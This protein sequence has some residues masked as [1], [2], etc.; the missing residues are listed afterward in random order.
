[1]SSPEKD[2]RVNSQFVYSLILVFLIP[3]VL[4]GN[5]F[6]G[7]KN[8]QK[9]Q[10]IEIEKRG[11]MAGEIFAGTTTDF[12][13]DKNALQTSLD[14]LKESQSEIWEISLLEPLDDG[15]HTLA[16][17]KPENLDL[18]YQSLRFSTAWVEEK[19]LTLKQADDNKSFLVYLKP[20]KNQAGAKVAL[21]HIKID[22]S[23]TIAQ[24]QKAILQTLIILGLTILAVLLLMLNHLRIFEYAVLFQRLKEVDKMKDDFISMA[25]HELK[26]PMA[27]IKGYIEMIFEG[28]AGKIDQ[29]AKSHLNKVQVSIKRLD[30][31]VDALLDVSRLEQGRI[32][33]DMQAVDLTKIV[34]DIV[35]ENQPQADEKK[36]KLSYQNLPQPHPF[37]FADPDRLRQ[38]FQ[39]L[40][41]NA[42]KYT[43]KGEVNVFHKIEDGRIKTVFLDTGIGM[44]QQEMKGLFGKFYRVR[45]EKTADIPGT[46]LGLWITKEL[47]LKMNGEIIVESKEGM[48]SAFIV[49]FPM[50]KEK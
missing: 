50:M 29:K 34:C 18:V 37:I 27:A 43:F 21:L 15:F 33:F 42:L 46:G 48:G 12:L 20:L 9:N 3:A 2:H 8:F 14:R 31:L 47:T 1:M 41:S 10:S 11:K 26:T 16:S 28:V 30:A 24:N 38:I 17:T 49:S 32:Q 23:T 5:I 7:L 39:N 6:W 22:L 40:L 4:A 25:S 36:L 35:A 45:S 44:T 19:T 13:N